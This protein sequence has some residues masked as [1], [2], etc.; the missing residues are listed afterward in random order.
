MAIAAMVCGIAGIVTCI[1]IAGIIGVVLGII[2]LVRAGSRPLEYGGKGMAI[3]GICTGSVSMIIVPVLLISIFLPSLS[4][5]REL[6]KRAGCAANMRGIGQSLMIYANANGGEFPPNTR[7]LIDAGLCAPK[8]FQCPSE[9]NSAETGS[10]YQYIRGLTDKA[11]GDWIVVFED[12]GNHNGEGGNVLYRDLRVQFLKEPDFTSELD[13][14]RKEIEE[15]GS[16][17]EP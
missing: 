7:L 15:S 9:G 8:M 13:R 11:P 6:A 16:D 2:A 10:D 14:V 4:R 17:G 3:T 5:A 12:P 1:P